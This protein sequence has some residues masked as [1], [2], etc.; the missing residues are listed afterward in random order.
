MYYASLGFDVVTYKTVRSQ[1]R[2]CYE[3]PNLQ[4]VITDSLSE[5][6]PFVQADK[7]MRGSWAV[8]F[9]MPSADP[10]T[11]RHDIEWTRENLPVGKIL[12]VSVVGSV[13]EGWTMDDLANDYALCARWAVE[14]GAD[15]V[16]TNFSC[17]NV[18]TCDGQLYQNA[19]QS[20]QVAETVRAAIGEVP[21]I[22]KIGHCPQLEA[23]DALV[24][25]VG[26]V[27]DALAMTNSIATAVMQNGGPLFD[28]E[29]RGICGEA[30]RDESIRQVAR[31]EKVIR[32]RQVPTK[33]I[34]VGGITNAEDVRRYLHAGAHACHLATSP[35]INPK[36]GLEIRESLALS[37]ATPSRLREGRTR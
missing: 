14:S 17:P 12:S 8:S 24:D 30:I 11:W 37:E 2:D 26:S 10:E 18:T 5:S 33:I 20:R 36:V 6:P 35:M 9:G 1:Q 19:E 23:M 15:C 21:Y 34:G 7:T 13:Q 29:Q 22:I 3:L 16:E 28:G 32:E 25:A 27:A 4:P 31:F